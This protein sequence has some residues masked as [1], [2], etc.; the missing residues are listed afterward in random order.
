MK[1]LIF[2]LAA[3][4]AMAFAAPASAQTFYAS[5]GP[6][7][8][9]GPAAYGYAGWWGGPSYYDYGWGR[10]AVA[11]Y[12]AVPVARSYVV[13]REPAPRVVRRVVR[14]RRIVRRGDAFGA[15]AYSPAAVGYGSPYVGVRVGF[16]PRYGW[17]YD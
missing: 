15:Y 1:K 12:A 4:A 14:E 17:Y 6:T 16:G 3:A 10:P 5:F 7:W 13:V 8:G 9:Y 2:G 11:A